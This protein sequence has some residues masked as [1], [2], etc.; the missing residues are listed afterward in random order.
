VEATA[1]NTIGLTLDAIPNNS[2]GYVVR[3]G[4]L[5]GVNTSHL[6]EGELVWLSETT[7]ATTSTRPTAPAHSVML[8]WC[9]KQGG[10]TS[11]IVL[12][13]VKNGSELEEL[14]DV[15]VAS[16]T[17][18]QALRKG[19]DGVWRGHT[20]TAGDVGAEPAG[21]AASSMAAHLAA[22]DPHSGYTTP[23]EAAAAA[24]VQSVSITPPAGWG[25][26]GPT[27]GNVVLTLT[28]PVGS[29]LVSSSDRTNWDGAYSERLQW[30]GSS[31][32]LNAVTGRA[33]L[34]LGSAAQS[35]VTDFAPASHTQSGS[36]ITGAYTAAGLTLASTRLLG[37]TTTGSGAA[38]EISVV[39]AT[40]AGGVLTITGGS[41]NLGYNTASR[42]V[43]SSSGT[44]A[45]LPLFGVSAAGL[46]PGPLSSVGAFLRDDGTWATPAG[47][48]GGTVNSVGLALPGSLF[49]VTGSPVTN[50]G[51]LTGS[52]VVQSANRVWA[53]PTNGA[54]SA[55]TFRALVAAD[56]PATT[57][58]AGSYG[59]ATQVAQVT[60]DSTGR[61]TFVGNVSIS[62]PSTQVTGLGTL[63]TQSGTFSGTSSGTNTGDQTIT[64]TGDVT[65]SG[66]GSFT[67][68]LANT[69]VAAGTY[70]SATQVAQVTVDS[71][72]RLTFAGNVSISIP[73]TQV[74]GLGGFATADPAAPPAIGGTTPAAGTFSG[75]TATIF[76]RLPGAGTAASDVYIASNFL[77]WRDG[78]NAEQVA[79]TRAGNLEN[80]ASPATALA[81]IGGQAAVFPVTAIAYAA[82]VN[83]DITALNNNWVTISLTG[84]LVFTTS[85]RA[86]GRTVVVQ[87]FCDATAR[88]LTFPAA[89][90][91]IGDK[92]SSIAASKTA[93]LTLAF[94]GTAD[95]NCTAGYKAQT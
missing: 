44:P 66:T 9:I 8:G 91:F 83:L 22:A 38:E 35:L 33:S 58:A 24:P 65:G 37:R 6:V 84:N 87:L 46:V 74:T 86:S 55:P 11:G 1:A 30:D 63:A 82:T 67:A 42:Q 75:L 62:I 60:V 76:A 59:S 68:T 92:P 40:L 69:A 89:W 36:T 72:G 28:L 27:T 13:D 57:V 43:T 47:S 77:R 45:T 25:I 12:V 81:N 2:N 16:A 34:G 64:L 90:N 54:D 88:N 93:V 15:S 5:E 29:T 23:G 70:G 31:T 10:G 50:S 7:G 19:G 48:G 73:S 61:L 18:G 32:G 39:G 20:Y 71:K 94:T 21:T 14:H 3:S 4:L 41:T 49:S 51:T 53:G 26:S 78:A 85:N 56:L 95:T 79:L 17:T 80:L 52:L